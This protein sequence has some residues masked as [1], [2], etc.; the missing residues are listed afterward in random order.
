LHHAEKIPGEGRHLMNKDLGLYEFDGLVVLKT[1][2]M[3]AV[4]LECGVIVNRGEEAALEKLE[5]QHRI[6]A[7]A[8]DAVIKFLQVGSETVEG[9]VRKASQN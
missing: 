7:A 6:A 4:L 1:A 5:V 3:P 9:E 2:P 8:A